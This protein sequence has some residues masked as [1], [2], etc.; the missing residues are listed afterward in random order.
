MT[1]QKNNEA[2]ASK[3]TNLQRQLGFAD[4]PKEGWLQ[5]SN[6]FHRRASDK[7]FRAFSSSYFFPFF[8]REGFNKVRRSLTHFKF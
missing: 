2:K 4:F 6:I 3:R 8:L 7:K 1:T 5:K